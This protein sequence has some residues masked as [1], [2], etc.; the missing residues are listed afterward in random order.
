MLYE[1]SCPN[2]GW[3]G[4]RVSRIADRDNQHCD[5]RIAATL[6]G[7]EDLGLCNEK[8][9]REEYSLTARMPDQWARGVK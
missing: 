2:C 5:Q 7:Q 3:K 4:D 8:L 6:P 9:V 1:Y